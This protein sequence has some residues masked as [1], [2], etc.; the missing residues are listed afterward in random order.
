MNITVGV[1]DKVATPPSN[2]VIVC[3]NSDYTITF[4]FDAEWAAETTKV[5]RFVWFSRNKVCSDEVAFDG[6]TVA[7]P[8]LANTNAVHV[9]VYAG[10]LHT[11]TPAKIPCES[12]ILCYGQ[13][14]SVTPNALAQMKGQIAELT[15]ALKEIGVD[16]AEIKKAVTEYLIQNPVEVN[17]T[18]P[19]VPAWA[20]AARKPTYTAAEVGAQPEGNYV[21]SVNGESPDEDGNVEIETGSGGSAE[22][23][24]PAGGKAGQYLC[25]QSDDD[26][27]VVWCDLVIP[28]QYGLVSYNQDK[29][30]TIT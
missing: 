25:K 14:N 21:K 30:I 13:D 5:A 3:G 17:E 15:K 12:S 28:E 18:D 23:G 1:V 8:V 7:V 16:P 9:G 26:Y 29:T 6:N 22:N 10:N 11:T 24:I 27:D 20:K 19:T 2:A 4:K